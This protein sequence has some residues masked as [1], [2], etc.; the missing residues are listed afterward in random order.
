MSGIRPGSFAW[1]LRLIPHPNR[2]QTEH[3]ALVTVNG[4]RNLGQ[5]GGAKARPSIAWRPENLIRA[6]FET[7]S[8]RSAEIGRAN[9][10]Q[11]TDKGS[12]SSKSEAASDERTPHIVKSANPSGKTESVL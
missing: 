9:G 7:G 4:G 8:N 5:L 10:D 6:S 2:L 11:R 12:A 3:R 1:R